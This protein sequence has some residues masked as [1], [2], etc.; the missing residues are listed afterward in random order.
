ML[1][2]G[3]IYYLLSSL[4]I[5]LLFLFY[6]QGNNITSQI[7][8]CGWIFFVTSC[9]GHA[10]IL[11]LA[12]FLVFYVP[13]ALLRLKKLSAALFVTAVS[14]LAMLVFVNMQVF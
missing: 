13:W 8:T 5:A 12:L 4:F 11:V 14:L 7:D 9:I 3:F 1:K 10:A 2:K 6:I